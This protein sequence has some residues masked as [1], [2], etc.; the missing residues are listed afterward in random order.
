MPLFSAD[1]PHFETGRYSRPVLGTMEEVEGGC[2]YLLAAV[3]S[4]LMINARKR[5]ERVS[6]NYLH[7]SPF[8]YTL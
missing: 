4:P 2:I 1:L 5:A 8:L 6:S 3:T 7:L